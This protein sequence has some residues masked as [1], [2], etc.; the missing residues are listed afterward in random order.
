M[1]PGVFK[2]WLNI[3]G[4]SRDTNR[5]TNAAPFG[6]RA[7]AAVS[8]SHKYG[9]YATLSLVICAEAEIRVCMMI[10]ESFL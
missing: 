4:P 7:A 8:A 6:S 1:W 10:L 9:K 2:R 3:C 5:S